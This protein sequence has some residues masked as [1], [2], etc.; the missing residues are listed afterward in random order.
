MTSR[1]VA[2]TGL[3]LSGAGLTDLGAGSERGG[4]WTV[5]VWG[6]LR[7]CGR[8]ESGEAVER[9]EEAGRASEGRG[10]VTNRDPP[11]RRQALRAGWGLGSA[12]GES[13]GKEWGLGRGEV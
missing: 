10:L 5:R 6:G 7:V 4:A 13:V 9:G 3:A 12:R 8:S 1:G 2:Y 11:E